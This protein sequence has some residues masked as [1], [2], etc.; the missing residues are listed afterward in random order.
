MYMITDITY[1]LTK[2]FTCRQLINIRNINKKFIS[3][4][5]LT[6]ME[7]EKSHSKLALH[8]GSH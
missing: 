8:M 4:F 3:K 1:M 5:Y 7:K 2:I 6:N